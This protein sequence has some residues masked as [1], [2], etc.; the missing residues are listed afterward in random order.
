M[1]S[2]EALSDSWSLAGLNSSWSDD[3]SA[4]CKPADTASATGLKL[5]MLTESSEKSF[6]TAALRSEG[7]VSGGASL[8]IG[9]YFHALRRRYSNT[10]R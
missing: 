1:Y 6:A 5:R 8:S 2:D 10:V 4:T 3:P 7:P 9:R